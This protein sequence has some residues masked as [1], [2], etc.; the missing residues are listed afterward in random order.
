MVELHKL[1]MHYRMLHMFPTF[2]RDITYF[3]ISFKIPYTMLTYT[4][5]LH[6]LYLHFVELNAP[7]GRVNRDLQK[8]LKRPATPQGE[9]G[10]QQKLTS[11]LI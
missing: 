5:I 6:I 8:R 3:V 7:P 11:I 10:M 9:L 4:Q 2:A 1:N